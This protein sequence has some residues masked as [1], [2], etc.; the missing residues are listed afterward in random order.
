MRLLTDETW[1]ASPKSQTY[2]CS[3]SIPPRHEQ[4]ARLHVAVDE[5]RLVRRVERLGCLADEVDCA[6]RLERPLLPEHL[7]KV[8]ALDVLHRQVEATVVLTGY[9]RRYDVRMIEA[10]RQLGLA[11]EALP[12]AFVLRDLVAEQLQ[13]RPACPCLVSSAR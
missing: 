6:R 8:R 13:R 4:V 9:E 1:R 7:A 3:T 12:E 5:T 11:Q 10:R 2:T